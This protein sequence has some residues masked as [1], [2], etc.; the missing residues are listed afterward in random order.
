MLSLDQSSNILKNGDR[1]TV[2]K[3]LIGI[4]VEQNVSDHDRVFVGRSIGLISATAPILVWMRDT[5]G[6]PID[7]ASIRLSMEL[8][9]ID[10][11]TTHRIFQAHN[12]A[13]DELIQYSIPDIPDELREPLLD[14]LAE[15]PGYGL[16]PEPDQH[17]ISTLPAQHGYVVFPAL[18]RMLDTVR[19][20]MAQVAP[21]T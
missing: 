2:I 16:P 15:T 12:E 10:F 20:G 18:E 7:V 13:G 6:V 11:L 9:W 1:D 14:Y 19:A 5:H 21:Y 4:V 17:G 3:F 8:A